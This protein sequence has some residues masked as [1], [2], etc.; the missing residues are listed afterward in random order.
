MNRLIQEYNSVQKTYKQEPKQNQ[1]H[2]KSI[3]T[4]LGDQ[5]ELADSNLESRRKVLQEG[6]ISS[7]PQ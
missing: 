4:T 7:A 3:L 6:I 5:N 1:W 2:M